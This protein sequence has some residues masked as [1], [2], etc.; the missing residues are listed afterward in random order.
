MK[1]GKLTRNLLK[2]STFVS[3]GQLHVSYFWSMVIILVQ[4]VKYYSVG[5]GLTCQTF[6][7]N[8]EIC[9]RHLSFVR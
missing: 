8:S 2:R 4:I 1:K 3:C 7:Q 5:R 6:T 9:S